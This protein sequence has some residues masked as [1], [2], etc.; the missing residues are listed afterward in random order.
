MNTSVV[1]RPDNGWQAFYE[2]ALRSASSQIRRRAELIANGQSPFSASTT[3]QEQL[4]AFHNWHEETRKLFLRKLPDEDRACLLNQPILESVIGERIPEEMQTILTGNKFFVHFQLKDTG[5][6]IIPITVNEMET[7]GADVNRDTKIADS[8][9]D[10]A[11]GDETLVL[12]KV[13]N[14]ISLKKFS[15]LDVGT[16]TLLL[17]AFADFKAK[18]KGIDAM[19]NWSPID[20][21]NGAWF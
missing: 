7:H 6:F 20:R 1:G 15:E 9:K 8:V 3:D 5:E 2:N 4:T 19:S 14:E 11:E 13:R 21:N 17:S 10:L 16:K 12:M 18:V